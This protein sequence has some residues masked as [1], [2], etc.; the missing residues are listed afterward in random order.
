MACGAKRT[1][2]SIWSW[3]SVAPMCCGLGGWL[4][5][6]EC[7]FFCGRAMCETKRDN[8][9]ARLVG[10]TGT[11][12]KGPCAL[13]PSNLGS[14]ECLLPWP[15]PQLSHLWNGNVKPNY[16]IGL[17]RGFNVMIHIVQDTCCSRVSPPP[18]MNFNNNS[19][20]CMTLGKQARPHLWAAI[21]SSMNEDN[22]T[23]L[24]DRYVNMQRLHF[25]AIYV[26]INMWAI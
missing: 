9:M 13:E 14:N 11:S 5:M 10:I 19:D 23:Y 8:T 2:S 22:L 15:Q 1:S 25:K 16:L 3:A 4:R 26:A 18:K 6:N 21:S 24:T 17:L 12:Q 7:L 20:G